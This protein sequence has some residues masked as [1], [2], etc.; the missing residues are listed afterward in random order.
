MAPM[1]AESSR[2]FMPGYFGAT[3]EFQLRNAYLVRG[4]EVFNKGGEHLSAAI[5]QNP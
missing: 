4:I 5:Q 1:P 3:A 2:E